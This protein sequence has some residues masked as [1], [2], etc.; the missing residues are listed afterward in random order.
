MRFLKTKATNMAAS[1][2]AGGKNSRMY[3][4]NKAFIEMNGTPIIQR[5]IKLLAGIFEEIII[6]PRI[7]FF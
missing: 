3:G 1:V 4:R 5:T 6:V 7:G 2:L